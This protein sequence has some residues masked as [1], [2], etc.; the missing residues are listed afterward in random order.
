MIKLNAIRLK[1]K[2][3]VYV[4]VV[5]FLKQIACRCIKKGWLH[6]DH[7]LLQANHLSI[8]T[9]H[10]IAY[11]LILVEVSFRNESWI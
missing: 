10:R 3:V 5:I 11:G 9:I 6:L 8:F 4:L 2:V 1:L 7:L